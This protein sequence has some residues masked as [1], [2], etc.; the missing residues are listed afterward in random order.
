MKDLILILM[1]LGL[2][3]CAPQKASDAD[4]GCVRVFANE[5]QTWVEETN[6]FTSGTYRLHIFF[7]E[8][9]AWFLYYSSYTGSCVFNSSWKVT[10]NG[11][12]QNNITGFFLEK[13][14]SNLV[15]VGKGRSTF[16]ETSL[17]T[18]C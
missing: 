1:V 12:T 9:T 5:G 8:K 6:D 10:C 11:L 15:L 7:F 3:A 18:S 17:P 13:S 14:G 2:T 4:R 16:R